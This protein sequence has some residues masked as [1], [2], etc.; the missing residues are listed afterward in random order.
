MIDTTI[1]LIKPAARTQ[2]SKGV[3]R[4]GEAVS[5]EILARMESIN[6]SEF[7]AGGQTGMRPELRFTVFH[8]EYQGEKALTWNGDAYAVYRTYRVPGTDDLELYVQQEVGVH[9][10][11]QDTD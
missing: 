11:T 1:T 4:D 7:F 10:G 6:R 2:D 5:R 9:N 3:W 8:A